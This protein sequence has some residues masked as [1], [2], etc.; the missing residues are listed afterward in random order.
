MV[1]SAPKHYT[2]QLDC[3]GASAA[4]NV[5]IIQSMFQD[6]VCFQFFQASGY[7]IAP[8]FSNDANQMPLE[9]GEDTYLERWTFDV[10]I[11]VNDQLTNTIQTAGALVVQPIYTIN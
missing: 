4:D 10:D 8:L 2:I 5:T 11:H 7:D 9:T 6:D 3:Y 1:Y